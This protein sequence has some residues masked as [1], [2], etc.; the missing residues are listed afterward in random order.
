MLIRAK[1][2]FIASRAPEC[3]HI[4]QNYAINFKVKLNLNVLN[5][6]GRTKKRISLSNVW[7]IA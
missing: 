7:F 3:L 1:Y 5:A 2:F 6:A 4:M